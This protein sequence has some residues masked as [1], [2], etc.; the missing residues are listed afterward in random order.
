MMMIRNG[1]VLVCL[2]LSSAQQLT[3]TEAYAKITY[4]R[5]RRDSYKLIQDDYLYQQWNM[6]KNR[7]RERI[8]TISNAIVENKDYVTELKVNPILYAASQANKEIEYI[9][10]LQQYESLG[11]LALMANYTYYQAYLGLK[12]MYQVC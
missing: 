8:L 4:L 1:I 10:A 2:H 11:L 9:N 6:T 7:V 3:M 5:E 12:Q